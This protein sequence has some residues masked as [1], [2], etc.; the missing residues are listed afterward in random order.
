MT[1][2]GA[3]LALWT[4]SD[5]MRAVQAERKACAA[6]V[7]AEYARHKAGE[8]ECAERND[9]DEAEMHKFEAMT[10]ERLA[11]LI[12]QRGPGRPAQ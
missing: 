9:T 12:E 6:L 11:Q 3:A 1:F 2:K 7:W 5:L 8:E 10:L 4:E